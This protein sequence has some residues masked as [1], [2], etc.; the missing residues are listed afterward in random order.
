MYLYFIIQLGRGVVLATFS[1]LVA[2][3]VIMTALDVVG[4]RGHRCEGLSA[5]VYVSYQTW[6]LR[7]SIVVLSTSTISRERL[8]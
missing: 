2:P 1:S 4:D 6:W 3:V 7:C 5:S 8:E